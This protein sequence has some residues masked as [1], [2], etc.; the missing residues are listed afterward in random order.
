MSHFGTINGNISFPALS[1]EPEVSSEEDSLWEESSRGHLLHDVL[2]ASNLPVAAAGQHPELVVS[3]RSSPSLIRVRP[4]KKLRSHPVEVRSLEYIGSYDNNLM[5]PICRCPFVDPTKLSCEHFFCRTCITTALSHQ[6]SESKSCPTCRRKTSEDSVVAAPKLISR[7][8]DELLVKC[9][10]HQKGCPEQM[11]RGAIQDHVDHYCGFVNIPCP[12]KKCPLFVRRKD[13]MPKQC[14]HHRVHCHYC[15]EKC[16]LFEVESHE[17]TECLLRKSPCVHCKNEVLH[18]DLKIHTETCPY[19]TIPCTAAPYGCDFTAKRGAIDQHTATCPLAKLTPLLKLQNERLAA[20]E[21]ALNH[22]RLK[23]SLLESSF[24]TIQETLNP[25]P[26]AIGASD[27][28]FSA[29]SNRTNNNNSPFES[30][31]HHLL[32]LHDSLRDEVDRVSAALSELDA[33][34]S[35]MV[36][37]ETLRTKEEFAHMNGVVGGMRMQ[38]HWLMETRLQKQ[39]Q[40]SVART[41]SFA[42]SS[43]AANSSGGGDAGTMLG[44][45]QYARQDTKL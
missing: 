33:K 39:A 24:A 40:K 25:T 31:N 45:S 23:N 4:A 11:P 7:I 15:D 16:F 35:L 2:V 20:H 30:T 19:A 9:A 12:S 37:N 26:D 5:C 22:L 36:L 44:E 10:Y 41:T 17:N 3:E 6:G 8:L 18:L 1:R 28:L 13:S 32:C 29:S 21:T 38:L 27:P 43:S 14:L 34:A 42:R